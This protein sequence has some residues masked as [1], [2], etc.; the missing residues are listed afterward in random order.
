M[1][2]IEKRPTGEFSSYYGCYIITMAA[3]LFLGMI[4][5]TLWSLFAQ[6]RALDLI[7]QEGKISLPT[8]VLDAAQESFLK[9]RLAEFGESAKAGRPAEL[10]LNLEEMNHIICQAPDSG[11]GTYRDIVRITGTDPAGNQLNARLC[12]P[13]KRLKF[14]E[15]KF[16]YLVGEGT[17][18]IEIHEE[19]LDAK[20]VDVKVP[21][22]AVPQ[23]FVSNLE[24]WPWVAPYRKQEPLGT[25]LKGIKKAIVAPEGLKLSTTP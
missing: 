21:G 17:F 11:Y 3:L 20:L 7:T 14:W 6:N 16:R 8:S 1:A 18:K 10:S 23:G 13:L 15:G 5:W 12:M 22:K 2:K 4:G 24:I 9:N 25:I 19:G